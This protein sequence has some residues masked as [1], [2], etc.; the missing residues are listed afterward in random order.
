MKYALI[1]GSLPPTYCGIGQLMP[2]ITR[3][4]QNRGHSV[5][6]LT[7]YEQPEFAPHNQNI[8]AGIPITRARL[9]TPGGWRELYDFIRTQKPDVTVIQYQTFARNY[10][11]G[12]FPW[13]AALA[14][15]PTKIISTIHEFETFTQKGRL[16]QIPAFLGSHKILFAD[17]LQF[18]T[19][20]PYTHNLHQKKSEV[21]CFGHTAKQHLSKFKTKPKTSSARLELA[22]HGFIQPAKGLLPLLEAL[23]DFRAPYHLHI[24]GALEPLLD[25]GT[26]TEVRRYQAK[27]RDFLTAYPTVAK[28]VTIYGD[29]DPST[30][31]F[32]KILGQVELAVFPFR[33][34]LTARR[35]SFL[36]TF[37]NSNAIVASSRNRF[38]E[39]YL[40][41]I[42][43]C[44]TTAAQINR[45]LVEYTELDTTAK[46]EIYAKQLTLR[47][48]FLDSARKTDI[49]RQLSEV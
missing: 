33:D 26:V 37:L 18:Q 45:F 9:R 49:Y 36:N 22:Y 24:L 4:L 32:Q 6:Y 34:G 21:L 29:T 46:Q 31:S 1:C 25:Y 27:I 15:P 7:D 42:L 10:L 13:V 14:Y 39:S 47:K 16:R 44:G 35:S 19:S 20:L 2:K 12:F 23:K 43:N 38:S 30:R 17:N 8:L 3:I 48:W 41:P 5:V 11:D 28:A 40:E